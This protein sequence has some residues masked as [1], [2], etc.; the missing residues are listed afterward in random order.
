MAARRFTVSKLLIGI[1]LTA[2]AL[3]MFVPIMNL[4]AKSLSNPDK[5]HLLHGYDILP[6]GFS[7]INYQ[8]VLSNPIVGRALFNSLFITTIGTCLSLFFTTITA[9]VLT[10]KNLVGKTPI[11]IFLIVIMIFEPGIVQEYMVV[12]DLHLLDSLWAMVLYRTINV[13]YLIIMMRFLEDIPDS[14][15]EAGKM[16]GAGHMTMF[17]RIVM[18]LARVPL[19]TIGMFY[20]I[21]RWNEFFKSSIFLSSR[22][23]TVLQVLLRQFVVERDTTTLVGAVDLLKNNHIAQLDSSALKAATIVIAMIPILMLYPI[24]LKY[25]TNGVMEGGIKE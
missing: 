8:V 17:W 21:A 11:M 4:I 2:I 7:L 14:L 23:N 22:E 13:Y 1:V 9:Y 15:L 6:K 19:L 3:T 18:P 25:Y 20:A 5:V 24:I 16:D 10:R 12:K